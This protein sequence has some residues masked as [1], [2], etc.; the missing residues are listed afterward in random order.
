MLFKR[1]VAQLTGAIDV[2]HLL[3]R[4]GTQSSIG[5]PLL[6]LDRI[7][8]RAGE[9]E[10]APIQPAFLR[11]GEV[12]DNIPLVEAAGAGNHSRPDVRQGP[13][14]RMFGSAPFGPVGTDE[15]CPRANRSSL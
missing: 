10:D 1:Y 6:V 11:V 12:G 14:E 15:G 7:D 9:E 5:L 13:A 3:H 8:R 4:L 2:E